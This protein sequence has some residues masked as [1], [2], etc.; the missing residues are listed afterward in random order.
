MSDTQIAI[1]AGVAIGYVA[2]DMGYPIMMALVSVAE[3][4]GKSLAMRIAGFDPDAAAER[5]RK[6]HR[7]NGE[8]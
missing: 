1:L 8:P 2:R 7:E 6:R 4:I 5:A 3:A